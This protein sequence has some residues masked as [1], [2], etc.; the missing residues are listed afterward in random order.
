M[1]E[2]MH[3]PVTIDLEAEH[4]GSSEPEESHMAS[5]FAAPVSRGSDYAIE[6]ERSPSQV[7]LSPEERGLCRVKQID[8]TKYAEGKL[9]LAKLKA[10]GLK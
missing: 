2:P 8:E 5:H 1:P 3:E 10:S 6:P 7:R 4:S 9:K